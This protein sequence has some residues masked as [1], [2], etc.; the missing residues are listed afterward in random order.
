[1][2]RFM[3][4]L[5]PLIPGPTWLRNKS[6]PVAAQNV[7]DY[8][9]AALE[10]PEGRGQ[11]F[12]IGGPDIRPYADLMQRYARARGLRRGMLLLPGIPLWFMA[13]G[14]GLMTPVP[15]PIAY[16]L[17][18]G[19]R[20]DSLVRD[21]SARRVFPAVR[22]IG[23]DEAVAESLHQLHPERLEPV[24]ADGKSPVTVMKHEGFFIDHRRR[25][26]NAAQ[27]QVSRIVSSLGG[28]NNWLHA[29]WLWKL[30]LYSERK[31]PG[32]AWM[33]WRVEPSKNG[34]MLTQ[35]CFF[36]PRGLPGFV[37]W[38]LLNPFHRLVYRGLI[39]AIARESEA[40]KER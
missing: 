10:N 6:Q 12:E 2:I 17:I 38:Y 4:E 31:A 27:E 1:M 16:A 20:S 3:T 18:D 11:I 25:H 21:E 26:V 34:A 32:Q 36:A 15:A 39:R 29:N 14:V 22:L 37:Y 9:L 40:G 7:M 23:Y 19:L 8:L 24:W 5:F 13:W 33:K 35:T 28:E 30:R